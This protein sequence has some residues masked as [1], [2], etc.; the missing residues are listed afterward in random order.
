MLSLALRALVLGTIQSERKRG[1]SEAAIYLRGWAWGVRHGLPKLGIIRIDATT[2]DLWGTEFTRALKASPVSSR[3]ILALNQE[4]PMDNGVYIV[5]S[6]GS[7]ERASEA[8]LEGDRRPTK[9]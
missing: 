9:P 8:D 5:S 2:E 7:P 3:Y 4:K 6:T 1:W